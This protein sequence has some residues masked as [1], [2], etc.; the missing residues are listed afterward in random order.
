MPLQ[1]LVSEVLSAVLHSPHPA[2]QVLL[3][4]KTLKIWR[5]PH[6]LIGLQVW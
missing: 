6:Q 2:C 1:L 4:T 5:V 3:G